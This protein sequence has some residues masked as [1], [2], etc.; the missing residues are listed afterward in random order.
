MMPILLISHINIVAC[1]SCM[2]YF[3]QT[4]AL[5]TDIA[6]PISKYLAYG[7]YAIS[8]NYYGYKQIHLWTHE[9]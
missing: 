1:L 5:D 4:M 8:M 3:T 6:R 2:L 7:A 9:K